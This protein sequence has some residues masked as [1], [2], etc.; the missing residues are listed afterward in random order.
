MSTQNF[1]W[2]QLFLNISES[3]DKRNNTVAAV[4]SADWLAEKMVVSASGRKKITSKTIKLPP[5]TGL[6]IF[7][8][9][10]AYGF[11]DIEINGKPRLLTMYTSH[12]AGGSLPDNA[13]VNTV[14]ICLE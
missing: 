9:R 11:Q 7:S 10:I 3:T 13:V 12:L 14:N 6:L 8:E 2:G 4:E 1:S 5:R